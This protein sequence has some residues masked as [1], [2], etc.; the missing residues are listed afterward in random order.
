MRVRESGDTGLDSKVF[1]VVVVFAVS[2]GEL[3]LSVCLCSLLVVAGCSSKGM[4]E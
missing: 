2:G 3:Y 1:C 4:K